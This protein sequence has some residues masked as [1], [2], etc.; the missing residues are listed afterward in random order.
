MTLRPALARRQA[1]R[2][3]HR[4]LGPR[5]VAAAQ[6]GEAADVG[7]RVVDALGGQRVVARLEAVAD[8]ALVA[9]TPVR[10]TTAPVIDG[11][12]D[13]A[14]WQGP[15]CRPARGARTTRCTAKRSRSRRTCGSPTTTATSTSRSTA[16][17]PKPRRSRRSITRRDNIWSDDWVGLSLDALGTGQVVVPHD[18]QPE[19]RA[20]RHAEPTRGGEDA[21]PDWVW[22]SAGPRRR[23]P[24]T[25]SRSACRSQP[26]GS[27]AATT[28]GW[29][30]CSG[31][32]SAASA[33]RSSW[34]QLKP[35]KWV[36]Q[37]HAPL[38]V[39]RSASGRRR[40]SSSRQRHLLAHRGARDAHPRGRPTTATPT[41]GLTVKYGLT[42]HGHPGRAP[43]TPTSAR[44]RATPSRSRS[45]SAIPLFF[46]EKRPVLHGGS[47]HLQR[48]PASARR[49]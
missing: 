15:D 26:S 1:D 20:G 43:S 4:L 42:S 16:T 40:A 28:C 33:S 8:P 9:L 30:C 11:T 27:R 24:A 12:L 2:L 22:D 21:S 41:L 31:G 48:W 7:R 45:T 29:A 18:G 25:P 44:S 23:R 17:I 19:R 35:N 38:R 10:A 47:G 13:D 3:A 14:V 32:A 46:S 49:R 6:L 39:P 36:F 34:P 37:H 5:D